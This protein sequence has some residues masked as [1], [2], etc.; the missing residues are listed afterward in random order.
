MIEEPHTHPLRQT[1]NSM[2]ADPGTKTLAEALHDLLRPEEI[3]FVIQKALREEY[4]EGFNEGMDYAVANGTHADVQGPEACAECRGP[5]PFD[6]HPANIRG[7]Y[8]RPTTDGRRDL[9]DRPAEVPTPAAYGRAE[10]WY[11]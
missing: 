6:Q 10:D 4:A 8:A 2:D 3:W 1:I 9:E 5:D 7:Q 11:F